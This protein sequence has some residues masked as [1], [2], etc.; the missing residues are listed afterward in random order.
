M[1]RGQRV[2]DKYHKAVMVT[3]CFDVHFTAFSCEKLNQENNLEK[4]VKTTGNKK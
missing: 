4:Y 2:Y 1:R 3:I